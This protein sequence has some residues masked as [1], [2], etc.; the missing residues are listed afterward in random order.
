MTAERPDY[1]PELEARLLEPGTR[2]AIVPIAAG[3]PSFA[4]LGLARWSS[5]GAVTGNTG[6]LLLADGWIRVF[7][8]VGETMGARMPALDEV[9]EAGAEHFVVAADVLGGLFALDGGAFGAA[10]GRVYYFA[11]DTLDWT[12]LDIG[13]SAFLDAMTSGVDHEFYEDLRWP[14]WEAELLTLGLDEGISVAPLLCTRESKPLANASRRAIPLAE[15]IDFH[16]DIA[17]QIDGH[18]PAP[19]PSL[20]TQERE[21]RGA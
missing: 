20:A 2:A 14:G 8:G 12:G 5:L 13:F 19:R 17:E 16:A 9:N 21:A 10:D 7:G 1:W 4:N 15:L 11:P 18:A 6:G 3:S